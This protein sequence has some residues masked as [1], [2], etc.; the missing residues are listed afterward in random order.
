[1]AHWYNSLLYA[2]PSLYEINSK[3]KKV[4]LIRLHEAKSTVELHDL[5]FVTYIFF[6]S[7]FLKVYRSLVLFSS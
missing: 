5:L 2:I 7:H 6:F 4:L 1:M 3:L